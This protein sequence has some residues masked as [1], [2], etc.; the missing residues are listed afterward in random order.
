MISSQV[1]VPRPFGDGFT[2]GLLLVAAGLQ[3]GRDPGQ[4]EV[5]GGPG[6]ARVG[7]N[8]RAC[9]GDGDRANR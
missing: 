3:G 9:A 1:E 2:V 8:A 4:P 6:A 5:V 7:M